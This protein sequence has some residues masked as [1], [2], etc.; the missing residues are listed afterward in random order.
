MSKP[1]DFLVKANN[2]KLEDGRR[3]LSRLTKAQ[4]KVILGPQYNLITT[5]MGCGPT[6]IAT[7]GAPPRAPPRIQKH[8]TDQLDYGEPEDG[9]KLGKRVHVEDVE[10]TRKK[11]RT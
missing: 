3:L 10:A 4:Q 8:N 9:T 6:N 11:S 1:S 7:I 5:A 2:K